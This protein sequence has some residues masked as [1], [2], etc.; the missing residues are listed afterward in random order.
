MCG[1]M[2]WDF[3]S[4]TSTLCRRRIEFPPFIFGV[5]LVAMRSLFFILCWYRVCFIFCCAPPAGR[6]QVCVGPRGQ[7]VLR[8]VR[9]RAAAVA[10]YLVRA[11]LRA[12][13]NEVLIHFESVFLHRCLEYSLTASFAWAFAALVLWVDSLYA[14]HFG[15]SDVSV[16]ARAQ[17][18]VRCRWR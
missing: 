12:K 6:R 1:R 4:V 16:Y 18:A 13:Q 2:K 8:E 11:C 7:N 9:T 5:S 15:I 10:R 17:E 14:M 3:H